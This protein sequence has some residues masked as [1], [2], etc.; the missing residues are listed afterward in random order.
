M[1]R[2]GAVFLVSAALAASPAAADGGA[3]ADQIKRGEA[4]AVAAD[5][6]GC[7]ADPK[8]GSDFSGGLGMKVP[9]GTI[10]VPNITPDRETGIG[11]WS[12]K[13]F[14]RAVRHGTS[15][16]LGALY[17]AMPYP[18]Y[19][20]MSDDDLAALYAYI[21]KKVKPV[22]QKVKETDLGW[23]FERIFVSVWKLMFAGGADGSGATAPPGSVARGSYLV[24]VL[25]HC[26]A[27]HT[28]R[29]AFL[30][31]VT[32]P[33]LAGSDIGGWSAPNLT[34]DKTGLASWTDEELTEFLTTGKSVHRIAGGDMGTAVKF[35]LSKL[36]PKDVKSIIAYLRSLP[37]VQSPAR[38]PELRQAAPLKIAKLEKPRGD[39]RK[40]M[41]GSTTNGSELYQA[42]CATCHGINGDVPAQS[43]HPTL[44]K[45]QTVRD[46]APDNLVQIIAHGSRKHLLAGQPMMP[47]HDQVFSKEQIAAVA[48]HVRERFGGIKQSVSADEVDEILSGRKG[49][50][51]LIANAFWLS[52]VGIAIGIIVVASAALF[53]IR[54]RK[55]QAA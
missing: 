32:S 1:V 34:A 29:G 33:K 48:S 17:P 11:G 36:P 49:L 50:P 39:W 42:A 35:S 10:Y 53:F 27:C 31:T 15:P 9:M 22:R 28:K 8:G 16:T 30:Q 26:G 23:P 46:N 19:S 45:N 21:M 52:L 6:A 20:G 38:A 18:S 13:D 41:D 24:N 25:G 7:H 37:P 40:M 12:L 47:G 54:R 4:V 55:H 43:N 44:L 5:C 2:F 3:D 14:D 51:W